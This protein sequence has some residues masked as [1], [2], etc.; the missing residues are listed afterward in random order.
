MFNN[1]KKDVTKIEAIFN[2]FIKEIPIY[3]TKLKNLEDEFIDNIYDEIITE[4][5]MK[6]V[7]NKLEPLKLHEKVYLITEAE[8]LEDLMSI[9]YFEKHSCFHEDCRPDSHVSQIL[10][11]LDRAC[12]KGYLNID[13]FGEYLFKKYGAEFTELIQEEI[14]EY[15]KEY[16]DDEDDDEIDYTLIALD[17]MHNP[18]YPFKKYSDSVDAYGAMMD[19][20]EETELDKEWLLEQLGLDIVELKKSV[21]ARF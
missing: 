2:L 12:G 14:K 15:K 9:L 7:D 10:H 16:C 1:I 6:I 3:A 18:I 19:W 8:T 13:L 4:E 17:I 21:N 5:W 20:I 11:V